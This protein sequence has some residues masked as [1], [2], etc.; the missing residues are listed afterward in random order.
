M[1]VGPVSSGQAVVREKRVTPV[2]KVVREAFGQ[3]LKVGGAVLVGIAQYPQLSQLSSLNY[4]ERD[5]DLLAAELRKQRYA[6]STIK[7]DE[8]TRQTILNAVQH[9]AASLQADETMIF[10]FSG[11]GFASQGDNY[12]ATYDTIAEKVAHTGLAIGDLVSQMSSAGVARRIV[13]IDACREV[14]GKA[15]TGQRS[16]ERFD[17]ASGTRIL[18]ATQLGKLSYED[19]EFKQGS[20]SYYLAQGLKGDAAGGDGLI[21]FRDITDF[22]TERVEI[23]GLQRGFPQVPYEAGEAKGDFLVGRLDSTVIPYDIGRVLDLHDSLLR[24]INESRTY[25]RSIKDK[26]DPDGGRLTFFSRFNIPGA[27][28]CRI[29]DEQA[30]YSCMLFRSSDGSR[31]AGRLMELGEVIRKSLP[32]YTVTRSDSGGRTEMHSITF[33]KYGSAEIR[34]YS[35]KTNFYRIHID[36]H[37]E[38]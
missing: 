28:E 35:L 34:L 1:Q 13:W 19:P 4:A 7:G 3:R 8:A 23:R 30:E 21:T 38:D 10:F 9:V 20:F 32:D 31:T 37:H 22:V 11:H 12:L 6:V 14:P 18:F 29:D 33:K 24:L 17:A 16:F 26:P 5:V 36:V 27:F 2:Q 25:F 15:P